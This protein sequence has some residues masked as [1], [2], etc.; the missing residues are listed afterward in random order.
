[1]ALVDKDLHTYRIMV[2]VKY[3]VAAALLM[4]ASSTMATDCVDLAGKVISVQGDVRVNDE[5][6]KIDQDICA[7]DK[8]VV[9]T[10][11]RAAVRLIETQTVVRIDQ[12]SEFVIRSSSDNNSLLSLIKGVL[13]LFSRKPNSLKVTTPYVT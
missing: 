1:M 13:H 10:V 6:A 7:G 2:I 11:S 12:N 3:I 4:Q 5:F 8:L 9:D